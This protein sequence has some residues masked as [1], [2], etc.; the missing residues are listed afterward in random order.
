[1]RT[2]VLPDSVQY[3]LLG[4]MSMHSPGH[5]RTEPYLV[6]SAPFTG[7]FL[8]LNDNELTPS[9]LSTVVGECC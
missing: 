6:K 9:M 7:S 8:H 4:A 5:S 3:A 1:M 2:A